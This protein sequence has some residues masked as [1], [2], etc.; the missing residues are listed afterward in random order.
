MADIQARL[1]N[2]TILNFPDGTPDDVIDNA[3]RQQLAAQPVQAAPVDPTA[4][5]IPSFEGLP[6]FE[7]RVDPNRQ[8]IAPRAPIS[9]PS[10]SERLLSAA[11]RTGGSTAQALTT[12]AGLPVDA[13]TAAINLA[14]E[15]ITGQP[16]LDPEQQFLGSGKV[17]ETAEGITA[18]ARSVGRG[19]GLVD[20]QTPEEISAQRQRADESLAF[21]GG[22]LFGEVAPFV[23]PAGF[24]GR[25]GSLVPRA[26]ATAFL[27]GGEGA[28]VARGRGAD[29]EQTL[30]TAGIGGGLGF[31]LEI[32]SPA[33]GRVVNSIFRRVTGKAPTGQL[34][35]AN[36]NPTEELTKVLD[37]AGLSVDDVQ[38]QVMR[39]IQQGAIPEQAER[40]A[41]FRAQDIPTTKAVITQDDILLGREETLLGRTDPLGAAL[42]D[43]I[44]QRRIATSDAFER[45]AKELVE[46]LGVGKDVGD[47]IQDALTQR[48]KLLVKEKN[49][50]YKAAAEADPELLRVPIL[51]DNI[52]GAIPDQKMIARIGRLKPTET[53]AVQDLL[54]EFGL[55][56]SDE[57]VEGFLRGGGVIEP[58]SF[59]NF[60]DFRQ[61][62]NQ[63][64]RADQTGTVSNL[65][66]PI[67][68]VLDDELDVAFKAIQDS[69]NIAGNTLDIIKEARSKV[70]ELK[71]EFDPKGT[72]QKLIGFK[73]GNNI[74]ITESSEVF[75][76]ITKPS[77][78]IEATD[79]I[80]KSLSKGGKTGRKA[81]GDLQAAVVLE[82]LDKSMQTISNRSGGRQLFSANAF[83]RALKDI[84]GKGKLDTIFANNRG[85][86]KTLRDLEKSARET[87]TP[88]TTKPKGS[89]PAVNAIL[90]VFS[91]LRSLPVISQVSTAIEIGSS[92]AQARGALD[93]TPQ[94]R[95]TIEFIT[96][97]YPALA[98]V[99]GVGVAARGETNDQ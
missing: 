81:L 20:P 83:V 97:E 71:V 6:G 70:R 36:L 24:I 42:A 57:A 76:A 3:V 31:G 75:R 43:P 67:I 62:L 92:S 73:K 46:D 59:S 13:V 86:L 14:S 37:D 22:E 98:T 29:I 55:D 10:V 9:G 4:A 52:V 65:I 38:S 17:R 18:G 33:I 87:T 35:D 69:P 23:T 54:I 56:Q 28:I 99:L 27:G 48:R 41:R 64:G 7:G 96:R 82:A 32:I 80:V 8:Q 68:N 51:S 89:A 15:S 26:I 5:G 91:G 39:E 77:T 16:L 49:A 74:P 21:A 19:V 40:A 53:A 30:Q 93:V 63:I 12:L 79:R 1:P 50:L 34:V 94:Q 78:S 88:G 44:R 95:K 58:L 11:D 60:E 90:G 72:T 66:N 85:M 25:I 61:G 84:D 47:S 45:N 2:G